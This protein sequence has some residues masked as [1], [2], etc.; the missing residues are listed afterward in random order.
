M[1]RDRHGDVLQA[2][3]LAVKSLLILT[4]SFGEGHNAAARNLR[5]AITVKSPQINVLVSDVF[6]DA[7]GSFSRLAEKGYL[8]VIN[9]LPQF[10][11][12]AFEILDRTRFLERHIGIYGAAA[13]RLARRDVPDAG[14]RRQSL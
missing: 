9:R 5:E 13:R 11:Q 3:E 14:S 4:A 1:R 6:L 12:K 7:Y 2:E 10:W 8:A